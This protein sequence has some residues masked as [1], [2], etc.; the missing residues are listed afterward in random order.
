[1]GWPLSPWRGFS[2]FIK[3]LN[4]TERLVGSLGRLE[5]DEVNTLVD[6]L[7][8]DPFPN[9]TYGKEEMLGVRR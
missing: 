4:S 9:I 8:R 1:M 2:L 5:L 3:H 6:E 7:H